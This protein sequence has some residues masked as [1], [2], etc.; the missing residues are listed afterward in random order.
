LYNDGNVQGPY[1]G[2][3]GSETIISLP[4]GYALV[5]SKGQSGTE[6]DQLSFYFQRIDSSSGPLSTGFIGPFGG[7][8]GGAFGNQNVSNY[9]NF[10]IGLRCGTELDAITFGGNSSSMHGGTGGSA[11]SFTLSN[12][13]LVGINIRSGKYIDAIQFITSKN[14]TSAWYGG[15]GGSLCTINLPDG[16]AINGI[17]GRSGEY[18]DQLTFNVVVI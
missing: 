14:R 10:T 4:Y 12:E 8:G 1:G 5:G 2:S 17:S 16:L 7:G 18:V 15:S 9:N 13:Y 6:I 3:G 11:T